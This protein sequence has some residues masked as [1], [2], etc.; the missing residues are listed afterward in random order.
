MELL[1]RIKCITDS[2][3]ISDLTYICQISF[4][5]FYELGEIN[6]NDYSLKEWND[7]AQYISNDNMIFTNK[8]EAKKH[9]CTEL[10]KRK[11]A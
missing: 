8:L 2:D 6:I 11:V 1:E 9:I 3:F 4:C 5:Q 10:F 7:A